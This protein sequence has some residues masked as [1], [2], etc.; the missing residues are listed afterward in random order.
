MKEEKL[1]RELMK[2][3][4]SSS[5]YF[6]SV[7]NKEKKKVILAVLPLLMVMHTPL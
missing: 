1:K 2:N 4:D 6:S 3:F 7:D 5:M